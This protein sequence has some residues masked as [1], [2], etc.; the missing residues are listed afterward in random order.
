ML[1]S[2]NITLSLYSSLIVAA[3]IG[4]A[5]GNKSVALRRNKCDADVFYAD[6]HV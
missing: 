3:D 4:R 1:I 6:D 2:S 5:R